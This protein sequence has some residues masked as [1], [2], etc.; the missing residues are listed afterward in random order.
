MAKENRY[1]NPNY[2]TEYDNANYDKILLRFKYEKNYKERIKILADDEGLS[3]TAWILRAI[4]RE[5]AREAGD[6]RE[7]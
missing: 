4:D 5:L 6:Y 2:K 7:E 1:K 3:V